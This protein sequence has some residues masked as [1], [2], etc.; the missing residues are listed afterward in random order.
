MSMSMPG[1]RSCPYCSE[2]IR[3]EAIKC[4]YCGEFLNGNAGYGHD[5]RRP[6]GTGANG[7][8]DRTLTII[9]VAVLV[10][11]SLAGGVLWLV[12]YGTTQGQSGAA[13]ESSAFIPLQPPVSAAYHAGY[14]DGKWYADLDRRYDT[15]SHLTRDEA[16]KRGT[17][18]QRGYSPGSDEYG[19]F[20][21]G[22]SAGYAEA[23]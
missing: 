23:R 12:V 4:R 22:Y 1:T 2:A 8:G 10:L 11:A 7:S 9:V 16:D 3:A 18:Y 21:A 17:G 6:A 19:D 15:Y 14:A 13:A 5:G 20:W